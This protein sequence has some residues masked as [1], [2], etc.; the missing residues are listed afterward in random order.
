MPGQCVEI[1]ALTIGD[2]VIAM[3]RVAVND[4]AS[5]VA[6][7]IRLP[8]PEQIALDLKV[9][10]QCRINTGMHEDAVLVHGDRRRGRHPSHVRLTDQR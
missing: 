7:T 1:D 8:R 2:R 6:E 4:E 10:R 3:R 9:E 5:L